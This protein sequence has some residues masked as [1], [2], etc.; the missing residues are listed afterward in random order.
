ML[1]TRET[2][3]Y[4]IIKEVLFLY[5]QNALDEEEAAGLTITLETHLTHDLAF[6]SLMLARLVMMLNSLLQA[7]PFAQTHR[8]SDIHTIQNLVDAYHAPDQPQP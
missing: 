3:Q 4:A 2:I 5:A 1:K 8:F 6:S 7:Q